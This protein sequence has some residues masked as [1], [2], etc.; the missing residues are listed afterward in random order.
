MSDL[1][2]AALMAEASAATGLS[3]FGDP[4]FRSGL[5]RLLDSVA[6]ESSLSK[7]GAPAFRAMLVKRLSNR[8]AIEE[9]YRRHPEIEAEVIRDPVFIVGLPRTGSTALG[10]MLAL[11]PATRSLRAWEAASPCPPPELENALTD[12]RIAENAARE[13]AFEA[14]APG[15]REALPRNPSAPAECF[16]LLELSFASSA[17]SGFVRCHDFH[18]WI[19]KEGREEVYAGY[20]YHRRVLKL[21]QWRHPARRWVLRSP[22][23]SYA[24]NAL[25]TAY[26]DARFIMTHRDP[27]KVLPSNCFLIAEVRKLFLEERHVDELAEEWICNATLGQQR[28]L[29]FRSR[30]GD[31][32]FIDVSHREQIADPIAT[33]RKVYAGLGWTF[34]EEAERRITAWRKAH[35]KGNHGSDAKT[36]GVNEAL[37]ND[38]FSSYRSRFSAYI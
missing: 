3:D 20:R 25:S 28:L 13:E 29:E 33:V 31:D 18:H 8:L 32:R 23:H 7:S 9:W 16:T 14:I 2:S 22:T 17:E 19:T 30:V 6:R 37:V 24:I 21:L 5:D 10:H 1:T 36:F 4:S 38:L 26:P 12:P 27:A 11:D 15:V 35:P 34:D